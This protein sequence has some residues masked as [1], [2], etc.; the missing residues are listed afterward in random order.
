MPQAS[1]GVIPP[2][3]PLFGGDSAAV[4]A[5][6]R[7]YNG[8]IDQLSSSAQALSKAVSEHAAAAHAAAQMIMT[9]I[10]ND[11]LKN[12]SGFMHWLDSTVD[13]VGGFIASHWV[14]FLKTLAT[15]AGIIATVCGI[16]AMVL[17]FIPGM[18]AFA[19][20]F[21]TIALLA[22]AVAFVC[23]PVLFATGHG[24][25]LDVIIDAVG[26]VTFG[27]GKGLIGSAEGVAEVAEDAS[28]VYKAVAGGGTVVTDI[29]DAGDAAAQ[30]AAKA[31][32]VQM[33]PKMLEEMKQVVS[34]RPVEIV[35][36]P[37]LR[38]IG[39]AVVLKLDGRLLAVEFDGV[40]RRQRARANGRKPTLGAVVARAFSLGDVTSLRKSM[41]LGRELSGD[42][43]TALVAV[44]AGGR[45]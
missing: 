38:R 25:L 27:I 17:A 15:V 7:K 10:D 9:A 42:F 26:L 12:P 18:Q 19:A 2:Q 14:G 11:G 28:A 5:L 24:S 20:A 32:D 45:N 35:T 40:Y 4:T 34:V 13:D 33:V 36:P 39:T 30:T 37:T 23:H 44:G 1:P 3:L 16:I 43:T 31:A 29:L 22:Q 41:R 8:T 6:K 21:E